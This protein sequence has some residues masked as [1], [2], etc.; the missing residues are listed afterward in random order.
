MIP[1]ASL[2]IIAPAKIN[3]YLHIVGRREDGLHLLD[4]L[5][6]FASIHDTLS[7]TSASEISLEI[8]GPF[9]SQ[10][11]AEPNNLVLQAARGQLVGLP[12]YAMLTVV[13]N[14]N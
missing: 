2:K 4:S 7:L 3:L 10:L 9:A 13:P 12:K 1:E 5:I 11:T 14:Y 6:T 8:D